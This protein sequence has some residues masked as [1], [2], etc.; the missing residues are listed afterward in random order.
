MI[1]EEKIQIITDFL[2][3]FINGLNREVMDLLEGNYNQGGELLKDYE[4]ESIKKIFYTKH[5]L[6]NWLIEDE[7]LYNYIYG[8]EEDE[9]N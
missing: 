3:Y 2:E 5:R 6:E 9:E 7:R 4:S 1:P 8:G